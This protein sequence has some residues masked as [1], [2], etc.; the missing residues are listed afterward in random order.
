MIQALRAAQAFDGHRLIADPV[1]VIDG[2]T[3]VAVGNAVPPGSE[4]LDLGDV[5]LLPGLVDAHQHLVFDGSGSLEEQIVDRTDDELRDRART[6]A[7]RA[8]QAGITTI[9]DLGDRSFIT[10]ELRGDP[11]LPTILAAGPPLTVDGGHCWFLGGSCRD[12][13]ALVAAVHERKRRG[14][15]IVKIMV[16]G[17]ALTPT[18]PMWVSQFSADHVVA[19]VRTAHAVGLPV[20]AHCHGIEGTTLALDAGVDTIEHCTF[21]TENGCSEP[22]D[23]LIDRIAASGTPVS[24]TWG[25]DPAHPPSPLVEANRPAVLSAMRR[26]QARG[27]TVVVGTDA[28]INAGKPHDVLPYAARDLAAIGLDAAQVLTTLTATAAMVCGVAHRKGRLAAGYDADII[29]VDGDPL[30]KLDALFDVRRVWRGGRALVHR[31]RRDGRLPVGRAEDEVRPVVSDAGIAGERDRESHQSC[32]A[33]G[34]K[35]Q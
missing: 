22:D 1:V 31:D 34:S 26:L 20:A 19:V 2:A 24:A 32:L 13:D 6:N 17:G 10:L 21:F 29:A 4:V 25:R 9:R 7:R 15:D 3:I 11:A 16:T 18:L 30:T 28:G 35:E 33:A 23:T 5:T 14:C 8:L 12:T 27:G